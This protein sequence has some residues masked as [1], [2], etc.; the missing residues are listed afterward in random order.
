MSPVTCSGV[1]FSVLISFNFF[2]D[3]QAFAIGDGALCKRGHTLFA[4][5]L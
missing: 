1:G 4:L 3:L 5:H 2:F